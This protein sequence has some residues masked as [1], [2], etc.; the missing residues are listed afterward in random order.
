MPRVPA[1]PSLTS[2]SEGRYATHAHKELRGM[3]VVVSG[4][5]PHRREDPVALPALLLPRVLAIQRAQHVK[6]TAWSADADG[7]S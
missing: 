4:E 6:D 5:D 3:S 1:S 2:P 7:L